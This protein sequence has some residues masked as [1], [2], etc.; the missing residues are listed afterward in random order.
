MTKKP[1]LHVPQMYRVDIRSHLPPDPGWR[2][3]AREKRIVV[4]AGSGDQLVINVLQSLIQTNMENLSNE[5]KS[6]MAFGLFLN[7]AQGL[8]MEYRQALCDAV[9]QGLVMTMF[10]REGEIIIDLNK[11]VE[12]FS[13]AGEGTVGTPE[14]VVRPSGLLIPR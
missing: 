1:T 2:T 8:P 6:T 14:G 9:S 4:T 7:L 11:N 5:N 13:Q 3:M 10:E 12:A